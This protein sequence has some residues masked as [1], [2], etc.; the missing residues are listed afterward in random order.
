MIYDAL[1]EMLVLYIPTYSTYWPERLRESSC[2]AQRHTLESKY[3]ETS[4]QI[5]TNLK[6]VNVKNS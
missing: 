3:I 4:K 1:T 2:F 6:C 5:K